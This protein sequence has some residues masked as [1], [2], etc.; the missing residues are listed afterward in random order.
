MKLETLAD[1][2]SLEKTKNFAGTVHYEKTFMADSGDYCYIDLGNVKGISEVSLNGAHLGSRWYGAHL[3]DIKGVIKE[4]ENLLTIKLTTIIGNYV[5]SLTDNP[6]AQR[7]TGYQP[8][9]SMGIRGPVRI[10]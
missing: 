9:T 6:V 7:W 2:I 4:G 8:Y 3:Y 10:I 1:L 5:K